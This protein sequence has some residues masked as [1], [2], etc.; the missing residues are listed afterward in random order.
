MADEIVDIT[1]HEVPD[2]PNEKLSKEG[3]N[4]PD[5][6]MVDSGLSEEGRKQIEERRSSVA[7]L[8]E[9]PSEWQENYVDES[10]QGFDDDSDESHKVN[11]SFKEKEM[12]KIIKKYKRYMKS[13][14]TEVKRLE[15]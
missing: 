6:G 14:L 11:I 8:P 15:S 2:V 12:K 3:V 4:I 10:T 9:F 7:S 13:N 1:S 5:S